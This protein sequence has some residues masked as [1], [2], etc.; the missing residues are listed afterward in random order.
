MSGKLCTVPLRRELLRGRN[1]GSKNSTPE[2]SRLC[3]RPSAARSLAPMRRVA[4]SIIFKPTESVCAIRSS[5]PKASVLP[6][7]WS[8]LDARLP[9]ARVSNAPVCT[10][11]F[12]APMPS[13]LSA[14][15]N[16]V[17]VFRTSGSADQNA[18]PHDPSLSW[19]TPARGL[20]CAARKSEGR[21]QGPH[22][23]H[24]HA[25]SDW[26]KSIGRG[27]KQTPRR[28]IGQA[29]DCG[30]KTLIYIRSLNQRRRSEESAEPAG[31]FFGYQLVF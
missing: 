30:G 18:G 24:S 22:R 2:D 25:H 12:Q 31:H 11:P 8:R 3:S 20:H 15:Q 23:I 9:L 10:G 14:A 27:Q 6:P 7:A 17:V 4:V 19:G 26:T 1:A 28:S 5:T 13:S 21:K 29:G 16:S